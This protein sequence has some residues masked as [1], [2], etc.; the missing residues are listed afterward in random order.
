MNINRLLKFS[1]FEM[2]FRACDA[3]KEIRTPTIRDVS[4]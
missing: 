2:R 3:Q 1:G 4:P